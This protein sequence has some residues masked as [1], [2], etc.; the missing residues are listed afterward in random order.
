[1]DAH[2]VERVDPVDWVANEPSALMPLIVHVSVRACSRAAR[3]ASLPTYSRRVVD[4]PAAASVADDL[5][6]HV[7]LHVEVPVAVEQ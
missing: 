7:G 5:G 1:M 6:H 2:G 3:S 4:D